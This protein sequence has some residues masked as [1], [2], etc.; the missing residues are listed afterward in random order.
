MAVSRTTTPASCSK[1]L[2]Q[3]LHDR[4]PVPSRRLVTIATGPA[5]GFQTV[6]NTR[7]WRLRLS[8]RKRRFGSVWNER[9]CRHRGRPLWRT[10]EQSPIWLGSPL[11]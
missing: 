11:V 4:R 10:R 7:S 6:S 5:S 9:H 1:R 2:E 3:A 8:I